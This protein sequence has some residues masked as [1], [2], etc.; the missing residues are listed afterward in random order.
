MSGA[1]LE[2]ISGRGLVAKDKGL[3]R[4]G[5]SDPY[6]VATIGSIEYTRTPVIKR[7]LNPRWEHS[8]FLKFRDHF[9]TEVAADP[10]EAFL[11]LKIF[12]KDQLSKDDCMG[13]VRVSLGDWLSCHGAGNRIEHT[14]AVQ[15][16]DESGTVSGELTFSLTATTEAAAAAPPPIPA[17]QMAEA[18]QLAEVMAARQIEAMSANIQ[19]AEVVGVDATD[20]EQHAAASLPP[21]IAA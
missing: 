7:S 5:K 20:R 11:V 19:V 15:K 17:Q 4:S 2:I 14:L 18:Q 8:T 1:Y 10:E 13:E 12:D 9:W 6:V 21:A 16:N 3:F